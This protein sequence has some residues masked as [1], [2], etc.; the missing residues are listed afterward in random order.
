MSHPA[1][2][3]VCTSVIY[4]PDTDGVMGEGKFVFE[5][6]LT[7]RAADVRCEKLNGPADCFDGECSYHVE[8]RPYREGENEMP[9]PRYSLIELANDAWAQRQTEIDERA[10]W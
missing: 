5:R 8:L 9:R 6:H 3:I 1:F 4:C 2:A 10:G 7:K